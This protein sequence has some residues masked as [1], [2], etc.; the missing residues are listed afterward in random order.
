MTP[1]GKKI[2]ESVPAETPAV[3]KPISEMPRS[4]T[5]EERFAQTQLRVQG[6]EREIHR[7]THAIDR[8]SQQLNQVRETL[9]LPPLDSDPPSISSEKARLA[10]LETRKNEGKLQERIQEV[11]KQLSQEDAATFRRLIDGAGGAEKLFNPKGTFLH[12]T[13]NQSFVELLKSGYIVTDEVTPGGK[14]RTPGASFTDGNFPEAASFQLLYDNIP[15]GG[16]D[17]RLDSERY[18]EVKGGTH[19]GNFIRYFWDNRQE[20]AKAYLSGLAQ[21]IPKDALA[22]LGLPEDRTVTTREQAM[23][24]GTFFTPKGKGDYGV[25]MVYD[26][27]K[28]DQLGIEDRGTVGLQQ[29]FEKRSYKSGGVAL[30]EASALLVPESH[31]E[32]VRQALKARGLG[33]IEIRPTEELEARTLLEKMEN[34][35]T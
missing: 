4:P 10:H 22:R 19:A 17:K 18:A 28:S 35:G 13:D 29:F 16:K 21:K 3:P 20:D 23:T 25:T 11:E 2:S 5:A 34:H 32:E 27:A 24:I 1:N 8:T 6:N 12:T 15:G 30:S 33:H 9:G 26:G 7:A 14:Q 31:I